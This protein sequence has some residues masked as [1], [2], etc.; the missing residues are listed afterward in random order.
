MPRISSFLEYKIMSFIYCNFSLSIKSHFN[1]RH[2]VVTKPKTMRVPTP[3][4]A[5]KR[6]GEDMGGDGVIVD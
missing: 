3:Y 1:L 6:E 5:M 4:I 2:P